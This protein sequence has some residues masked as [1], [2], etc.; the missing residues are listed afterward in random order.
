MIKGKIINGKIK[1]KI[2]DVH[3]PFLYSYTLIMTH[4]VKHLRVTSVLAKRRENWTFCCNLCP[5]VTKL[6][7]LL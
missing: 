7:S 4:F 1:K 3:L 6:P 5:K 2:V